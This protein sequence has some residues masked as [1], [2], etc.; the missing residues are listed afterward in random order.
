MQQRIGICP[1]LGLWQG[2]R[3]VVGLEGK[4]RQQ[5]IVLALLAAI[6]VLDQ[7]AKWW[8]WRHVPTFINPGGDILVGSTVGNWYADPVQGSLL[9]L[10]DLGLLSIAVSVLRHRRHPR[11]FSFPDA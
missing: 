3:S 5:S 11:G 7:T 10:L 9:D 1:D 8:A 6:I 4:P 2:R